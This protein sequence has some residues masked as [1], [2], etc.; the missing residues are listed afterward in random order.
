MFV[1]TS[2]RQSALARRFWPKFVLFSS[3][4]LAHV[5]TASSTSQPLDFRE[6][7]TRAELDAPGVTA[8][9][10]AVS[11]AAA[12]VGPAG[13]LPDPELV[14]GIDNLPVTGSDAF[15][16]NRDFMTMRKIGVMQAL[17]RREKRLLRRERAEADAAKARALLL[18]T[19]LST[20][21]SV[22]RAWTAV[23]NAERRLTLVSGMRPQADALVGGATAAISAGR[24]STADAI[25]AKQARVALEDRIAAIQLNRD[26][27]RIALARW[28][29]NDAERPV[30]QTPDWRE[31]P[32]D[33]LSDPDRIAAHRELHAYEAIARAARTD[34]ALARAEKRSDWSVEL[35]YADR[36]PHLSS[37]LSVQFRVGLPLFA[38]SRQDPLIAANEAVLLQIES[39]REAAA[40]EH[41]AELVQM[42][43]MWR[44]SV[45]RADRYE[46]Q[47]LPLGDERI[48]A[49]L[50]SYR[51]G[52]GALQDVLTAFDAA[53]EQRLAYIDVMDSLGESW[54]A[55]HFAFPEG[56]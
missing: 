19:Q 37:M 6:A 43:A 24:G 20:R 30:G 22:A 56:R 7:I 5:A 41:R 2:Y 10:A 47:L 48:E 11:A 18:T 38:A 8:R 14:V 4:A 25:A 15:E 54:A 44:A 53:I 42:E 12:R 3:L 28:L 32:A 16:W 31:L 55:L 26:Q 51:G 27:A 17:P 40:R 21:E 35:A 1:S 52:S 50:A 46:Q 23:A 29:P 45:D 13:E 33:V 34:I 39:E 49:A 36:G 9:A